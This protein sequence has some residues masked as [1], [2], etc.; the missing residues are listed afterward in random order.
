MSGGRGKSLV[1]GFYQLKLIDFKFTEEVRHAFIVMG[2][3]AADDGKRFHALDVVFQSA[4]SNRERG[5]GRVK[6]CAIL[7]PFWR[8]G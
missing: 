7:A 6:G 4:S 1:R 8:G 2:H 3:D 5:S